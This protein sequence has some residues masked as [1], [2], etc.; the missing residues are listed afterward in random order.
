MA[1]LSAPA[2]TAQDVVLQDDWMAVACKPSGSYCEH[3]LASV[4]VAVEGKPY[5]GSLVRLR[6]EQAEREKQAGKGDRCATPFF[7]PCLVLFF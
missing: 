7:F 3:V 6:D 5:D 1:A 4:E 2:I